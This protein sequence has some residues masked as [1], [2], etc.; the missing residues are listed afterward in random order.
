MSKLSLQNDLVDS[1]RLSDLTFEE[2]IPKAVRD[3]GRALDLKL[4]KAGDLILFSKK[5]PSW[6][7]R[8]II[9]VQHQMFAPEHACWHHVA[10]S[11]GGVQI[12]EAT[13]WGV[14]AREYWPYMTGEY[15]IKVRRLKDATDGQRSRVAY[16]AATQVHTKYGFSNLIGIAKSLN[17]GNP[18]SSR[19][20]FSKGVI[21]SQL[22]FEA[23]MREGF[24]LARIPPQQVCPAHLSQSRQMDDVALSWVK[25]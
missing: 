10:V 13:I 11:G 22:Y 20:L 16:F 6:I 24:L 5:K 4:L 14:K 15:D 1:I 19:T 3:H 2:G 21:C 23:C 9:N 25:V 18:W 17:S 8:S 7:N 12:T